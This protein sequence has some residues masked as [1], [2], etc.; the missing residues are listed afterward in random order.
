M[1]YGYCRGEDRIKSVYAADMTTRGVRVPVVLSRDSTAKVRVTRRTMREVSSDTRVLVD[2]NPIKS[3]NYFGPTP[4]QETAG[5]NGIE[6]PENV[7][8]QSVEDKLEFLACLLKRI[9]HSEED[10][11]QS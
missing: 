3:N 10:R 5:I 6:F 11:V 9:G 2:L 8:Y 7:R 4:L 1:N